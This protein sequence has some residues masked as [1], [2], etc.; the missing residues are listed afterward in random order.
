MI[1]QPWKQIYYAFQPNHTIVLLREQYGTTMEIARVAQEV[2]RTDWYYKI[3]LV[4]LKGIERGEA[5]SEYC[6]RN[7][8][9]NGSSPIFR[10][11]TKDLAIYR[12]DLTLGCYAKMYNINLK[13]IDERITNMR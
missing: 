13:L 6:R 8:V 1:L 2:N 10:A 9:T 3:N 11:P 5:T 4:V 7:N 12:C